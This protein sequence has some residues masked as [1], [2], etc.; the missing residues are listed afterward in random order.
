M[1]IDCQLL[2]TK[3]LPNLTH[4]T[5]MYIKC[6][7]YFNTRAYKIYVGLLIIIFNNYNAVVV[8]VV[9]NKTVLIKLNYWFNQLF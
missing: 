5:F 2:I 7:T 3:C 6:F 4:N 9:S 1:L 8:V